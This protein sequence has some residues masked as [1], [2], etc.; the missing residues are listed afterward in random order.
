MNELK[1]RIIFFD[2]INSNPDNFSIII[3]PIDLHFAHRKPIKIKKSTKW[4][5]YLPQWK[6]DLVLIKWP[7]HR[8]GLRFAMLQNNIL[9][10]KKDEW[11]V[12]GKT[13]MFNFFGKMETC[14]VICSGR[15][16]K[17]NYIMDIIFERYF[18]AERLSLN[19]KRTSNEEEIVE[20]KRLKLM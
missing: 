18:I 11:A 3:E 7:R 16:D 13:Y 12:R 8:P 15:P 1:N 6:G 19:M 4:D 9:P 14:E 20:P 17:L 10:V 5:P 2:T